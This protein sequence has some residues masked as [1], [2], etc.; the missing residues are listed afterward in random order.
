M[1]CA[2]RSI[3]CVCADVIRTVPSSEAGET[4]S[5]TLRR[6]RSRSDSSQ[7][8]ISLLLSALHLAAAPQVT[9][10]FVLDVVMTGRY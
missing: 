6:S 2:T 1:L 4:K 3:L 9:N 7:E 8:G 10:G 5:N